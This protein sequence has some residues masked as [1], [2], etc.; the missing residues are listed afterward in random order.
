MNL[1]RLMRSTLIL[2]PLA[3]LGLACDVGVVGEEPDTAGDEGGDPMDECDPDL[4]CGEAETCVDGLL[5]PTTCGPQN[6]D[7]PIGECEGPDPDPGD[8]DPMLACG[9]ALTCVDGQMY[10]STCGPANC[11]EPIGP[12]DD[13][14]GECDDG[15]A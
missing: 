2:V 13:E 6:C 4:A 8:C 7:E 14:P 3:S 15:G 11:D 9:D 1:L 10:P 5:Y 12:C